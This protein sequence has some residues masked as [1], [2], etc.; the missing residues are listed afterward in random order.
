MEILKSI[1]IRAVA[2]HPMKPT[3]KI[4]DSCSDWPQHCTGLG[5]FGRLVLGLVYRTR[6]IQA[7]G[8]RP[9]D[10]SDRLHKRGIG[11]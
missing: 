10:G 4:I 3:I 9:G 1:D 7:I 5:R 11:R 2:V 8:I 6:A